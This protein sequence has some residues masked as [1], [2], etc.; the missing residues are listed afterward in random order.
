MFLEIDKI[1]QIR[2]PKELL[3]ELLKWDRSDSSRYT[4]LYLEW[5]R[6][7]LF[8]LG[9][10]WLEQNAGVDGYVVYEDDNDHFRPVTNYLRRNCTLKRSQILGKKIHPVIR[11]NSENKD[12]YDAS[13]LGYLVLKALHTRDGEDELLRLAFTHAQIFGGAWRTDYKKPKVH[14]YIEI[15]QMDRQKT[16]FFQCKNCSSIQET[17][18][19][20]IACGS[21]DMEYKREDTEEVLT[22][23]DGNPV[24]NKI[25]VFEPGRALID[26]F[27]MK[28]SPCLRLAEALWVQETSIQTLDWAKANYAVD[29]EGYYPDSTTKLEVRDK[30]PRALQLSHEFQ[31]AVNSY[32]SALG[33]SVALGDLDKEIDPN[34]ILHRK[35]Y[36]LPTKNFPNGRLICWCDSGI[37]YDGEPD[38]PK[39]T[40]LKRWHTYTYVPYDLHPMRL[41]G[42]SYFED[43]IPIN[44]KINALDAM[45]MEHL[46]RTASP[47]RVQF[48]NIDQNNN[49]NSD[50]ILEVSPR[51]DLP[52]GG[53]PFYLQQPQLSSEIYKM[54]AEFV[55]E[56]HDAG[57]VTEVLR[58]I[59]PAGVDTYRGLQLLRDAADSSESELYNRL[60]DFVREYTQLKLALVQEC[61][62]TNDQD[63]VDMMDQIRQ[64]ENMSIG[65]VKVF[66]GEDLRNNLN[67]VIEEVDYAAQSKAAESDRVAN[68]VK[69]GMILPQEMEDPLVRYNLLKKLGFGTMSIRETTDIEKAER[70]IQYIER[71]D[72]QVVKTM[73]KP[74]IDNLKILLDVISNW[75]KTAKYEELDQQIQQFT[76]MQ[77]FMPLRQILEQKM[78]PPPPPMMGPSG[79]GGPPP[80]GRP[81]PPPPQ[82]MA[83]MPPIQ[84][85]PP[86]RR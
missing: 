18:D 66:S 61:L 14:E 4:Q 26:S 70:I 75:T 25:Q 55:S 37:L 20:C 45:I 2:D 81:M 57:T 23:P 3:S 51:P 83:P 22:G 72:F 28:V 65:Q 44:I 1:D 84:Q 67:I 53:A 24:V 32:H 82:G 78:N 69:D 77:L 29:S 79:A 50:G 47:D 52:N 60:Y 41:E 86:G 13:R 10:H 80:Q 58:G 48:T 19:P 11:P 39:A 71:G 7:M 63:L 5:E 6:N 9:K 59:R 54:R 16:E 17:S 31:V 34:T 40:K 74:E 76:E 42:M 35:L 21:P 46:D 49:D 36:H 30:L 43:Q 64:N 38:V 33:R 62:I 73:I 27:R 15:P 85:P 12:D 56:I 68:M 8:F